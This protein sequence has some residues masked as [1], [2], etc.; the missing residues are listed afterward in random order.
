MG[1]IDLNLK[2]VPLSIEAAQFLVCCLGGLDCS[3][4]LA[5]SGDLHS[6]LQPR[7]TLGSQFRMSTST[8]IFCR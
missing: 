3:A 4:V 8:I 2:V 7:L 1:R 6:L 5:R